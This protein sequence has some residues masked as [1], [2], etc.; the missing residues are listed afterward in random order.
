MIE[1]S[2]IIKFDL[3]TTPLDTLDSVIEKLSQIPRKASGR[4]VETYQEFKSAKEMG[5]DYFQGYF[6]AKPEILST[7]GISVNH[8]TKLKLI[9][10]I[11]NRTLNIKK[12]MDRHQKRRPTLFQAAEIRQFRI[13]QT[14]YPH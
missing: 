13:F 4:K 6:F 11:S 14:A 3:R 2:K 7:K 10:E 9:K 1:L 8:V 5:F 12:N